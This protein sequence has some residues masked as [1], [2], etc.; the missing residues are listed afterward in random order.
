MD[1]N[2]AIDVRACVFH[3]M[4]ADWAVVASRS[5]IFHRD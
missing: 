1:R 3:V 2:E 5:L 4:Q